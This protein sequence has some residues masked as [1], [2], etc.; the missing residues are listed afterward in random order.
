M[1]TQE[2]VLQRRI[3]SSIHNGEAAKEL[4]SYLENDVYTSNRHRIGVAKKEM[5]TSTKSLN[6]VGLSSSDYKGNLHPSTSNYQPP[7]D[8]FLTL[9]T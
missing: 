2:H 3:P 7:K 5:T 6:W 9:L 8:I 1:G 4:K